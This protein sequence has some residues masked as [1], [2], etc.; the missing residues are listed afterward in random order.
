MNL[1]IHWHN[2][3]PSAS[4]EDDVR[5]RLNK[6][7]QFCSDITGARVVLDQPHHPDQRPRQFAVK[8]EI[9]VPNSTIV[10]DHAGKPGAQL[11]LHQLVHQSFDA[12][13]RQV[14]DYSRVRQGKV[15]RHSKPAPPISPDTSLG[16]DDKNHNSTD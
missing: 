3:A 4:V 9:Q 6:L 7:E 5:K 2:L 16:D 10:V 12:A 8:L 1:E 11:D 15:K 13:R 14:Q